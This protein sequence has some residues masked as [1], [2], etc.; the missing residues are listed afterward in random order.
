MSDIKLLSHAVNFRKLLQTNPRIKVSEFVKETYGQ[1]IMDNP[2]IGDFDGDGEISIKDYQIV[3]NW[4]H[5]GTPDNIKVY[6]KQRDLA[7]Q[8]SKIPIHFNR[9][10]NI[11]DHSDEELYTE[12][13]SDWNKD[14]DVDE[15]DRDILASFLLQGK[16][17][18]VDE[19]NL[20]RLTY[21][22]TEDLPSLVTANYTCPVGNCC[23]DDYD[24]DGVLSS[25]DALIHY[26]FTSLIDWSSKPSDVLPIDY[27]NQVA[28][29]GFKFQPKH[30]PT[31]GCGDFEEDG[32]VDSSD[33]LIYY[34]W[35][36]LTEWE[37]KEESENTVDYFY[38]NAHP[39]FKFFPKHSPICPSD[40]EDDCVGSKQD[41]VG[42][43]DEVDWK[44]FLIFYKWLIEGKCETVDCFNCV[45][46]EYPEACRLPIDIYHNVGAN[47]V[48]F[49]DA[50]SGEENL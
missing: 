2:L 9:T 20:N 19:Y 8:A 44:D 34:A 43:E 3:I 13:S 31:V 41:C 6:N 30:L 22:K 27:Y 28:P 12:Y 26:A 29:H 50:Y 38:K 42:E 10:S 32:T 48:V 40:T 35:S 37:K 49:D 17:S 33:S 24:E 18:D 21:P 23:D 16:P 15:L 47:K 11:Q 1:Q 39:G 46:E 5:Q 14:G 25:K 7:P 4:I 36:S 45:R